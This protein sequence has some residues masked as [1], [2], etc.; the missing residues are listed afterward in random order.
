MGHFSI[1]NLIAYLVALV[2]GGLGLAIAT[3]LLDLNL[4]PTARYVFGAVLVL[5]GV[6]RFLITFGIV[7]CPFEVI[8]LCPENP[9]SIFP[10]SGLAFETLSLNRNSYF[11]QL[12][13]T[14][15]KTRRLHFNFS[16]SL[17]NKANP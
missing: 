4:Q 5:M 3:R 13:L 6:Y 14:S 1:S 15:V 17:H 9:P 12:F 7:T 8:L 10:L 16:R 11:P 2:T